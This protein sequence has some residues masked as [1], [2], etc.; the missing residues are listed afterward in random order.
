MRVFAEEGIAV[1]D[2]L[3]FSAAR[4]CS[5]P[6]PGAT[7]ISPF[8]G[9]IDDVAGDGMELIQHIVTIYRNYDID[10]QVLTAS[11]RHPVHFVRGGADRLARGTLPLKVIKTTPQAPAHRRRA[12]RFL[13]DAE[14]IPA[15]KIVAPR[16]PK[17]P[18]RVL[19]TTRGAAP[20]SRRP[21][22]AGAPRKMLQHLGVSGVE[23]SI[24]LV[25][26]PTIH[27]LNRSF[28]ARIGRPT[29][30]LF[31][32]RAHCEPWTLSR[33]RPVSSAMWSSPSRRHAGRPEPPA[34]AP[35]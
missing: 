28:G 18:A 26:D 9:R 3:C 14:K 22:C 5:P 33:R 20:V 30:S 7:Y 35:R 31:P 4:R 27:A 6:R 19:V 12:C 11:V 8:V 15:A 21:S 2:T 25:D 34:P 23:L 24:A 32:R 16:S 1:N 13:A 17:Q 29:C 10:T